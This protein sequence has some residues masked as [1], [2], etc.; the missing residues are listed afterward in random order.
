MERFVSLQPTV[1]QENGAGEFIQTTVNLFPR[2]SI[3]IRFKARFGHAVVRLNWMHARSVESHVHGSAQME[4]RAWQSI[5]TTVI[6]TI[7][8]NDFFESNSTL[9]LT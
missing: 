4:K 9:M 1:N 2:K 3:L 7:T 6:R 5:V 8:L